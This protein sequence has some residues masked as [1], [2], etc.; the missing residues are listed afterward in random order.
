MQTR[1]WS[2]PGLLAI[3][4]FTLAGGLQ[5]QDEAKT[6]SLDHKSH[7]KWKIILPQEKWEAVGS[8]I[9]IAHEGGSGFV[10]ERDGTKLRVDSKASGRPT[11]T[12]SGMGGLVQF[13]AR[14][15]DGKPFA[16][17][18]RFKKAGDNWQWASGGTMR[19]KF[20]GQSIELIDANNNGSY[21]DF[22]ADGI[23][24]GKGTA[25][26]MLSKVVNVKG[27]LFEV[28]VDDSGRSMTFTPF[29]GETGNLNLLKGFKAR[30][31]LQAAVVSS[32]DGSYSFEM[33]RA[34]KGMEVPVGE[35]VLTSGFVS[36]GSE[37]ARI[38]TGKMEPVSVVAGEKTVLSW[39][40]SVNLDFDFTAQ[41]G[42][43]TVNPASM[44]YYGAAGEEYYDWFPDAVSP[45][46]LIANA[47]TGRP[48]GEGR[49][50]GC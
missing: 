17:T 43:V 31:K 12:V 39:G 46:I 2:L 48:V 32:K 42:T 1:M 21:A 13:R 26:A 23:I 3:C 19:G 24:V 4:A 18:A 44:H 40:S 20:N 41:N 14:G 30:G 22:G 37:T 7:A 29:A 45:K 47:K 28:S 5:A 35:Y 11:A 9:P 33:S 49:F 38:R 36:A 34:K 16:Y 50:G 15:E 8:E 6:I 10:A 25:A 27:D